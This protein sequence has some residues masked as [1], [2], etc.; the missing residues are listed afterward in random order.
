MS[1]TCSREYISSID[2]SF[3]T[4]ETIMNINYIVNKIF[5]MKSDRDLSKLSEP[6][7]SNVKRWLQECDS[8][9]LGVFVTEGYRSQERQNALYDQGRKTFGSIVTW[10]KNSLHTKGQAV[11]IAFRGKELYPKDNKVW[12]DVAAIAKRNHIQW[13][14]DLWGR[15]LPHFQYSGTVT[16]DTNTTDYLTYKAMKKEQEELIQS[17][18]YSMKNCYNFGTED[19]QKIVREQVS[20]WRELIKK[21]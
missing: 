15:D 6:F 9:N 18:I 8:L 20:A 17:L 3:L 10:T 4:K 19:M 2:L 11:D 16:P 7:Q 12:K 1:K 14:Y 21:D 13:G 5:Y